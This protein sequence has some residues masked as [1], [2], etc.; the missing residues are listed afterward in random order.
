MLHGLA[1]PGILTEQPGLPSTRARGRYEL[2]QQHL[3]LVWHIPQAYLGVRPLW[4]L[5]SHPGS[6]TQRNSRVEE[7]Q[8]LG[9]GPEG[10]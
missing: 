6:S 1:R 3:Q 2:P 7:L 5:P 10:A 8:G 9:A 4:T